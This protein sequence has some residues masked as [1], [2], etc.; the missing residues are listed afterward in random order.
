[1]RLHAEICIISFHESGMKT[2]CDATSA[3]YTAAFGDP[4]TYPLPAVRIAVEVIC[5]LALLVAV[6]VAATPPTGKLNA[7]GMV[8]TLAGYPLP[9]PVMFTPD[10]FPVEFMVSVNDAGMNGGVNG[11]GWRSLTRTKN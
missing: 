1:M 2:S 3:V 10:T 4:A 5:P 7:S 11:N 8:D 6:P 9:A